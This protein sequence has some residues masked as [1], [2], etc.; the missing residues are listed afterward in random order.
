[1]KGMASA[2]GVP[3]LVLW[4]ALGAPSGAAAQG[5][6]G[7]AVE[8]AWRDPAMPRSWFE[9]PALASEL[10]ITE[11]RQSPMLDARVASGEL[12]PV[13]ERLPLDPPVVEPYAEVGA[14]GGT[15]VQYGV[16]LETDFF[17][18]IGG[19]IGRE[20]LVRGTPDGTGFVPWIAERVELVE[21]DTVAEITMREGMRWS[22]GTP[23]VA[24]EEFAF[25]F[26]ETLPAVGVDPAQQDP[27]ILGL[28]VVD[29]NTVR[30][31]LDR[32]Y[33]VFLFQFHTAF[34][35][36]VLETLIPMAPAH[37][38]REHL[39]RFV[40]EEEALARARALGFDAVEPL[41]VAL[42]DQVQTIDEPRLGV[43]VTDAYVA[44]SRT[45][46]ELVLERNPYYPF[47][48]TAGNQLPYIDR[49]VVRFAAQPDNVELQAI[50]GG[51]DVLVSA[52]RTDRIPV[53]I[54][55]EERG[56]YRTLIYQDA[57]LSKPFYVFN[58]TPPEA[59]YGPVFA[60]VRF[61][62]AM[63]L[64]LN[65]DGINDRFYFG[66]GTPTQATV[67]PS[68]PLFRPEYAQAFAGHDPDAARAL[69]DEMGLADRDGD[70]FRDFPDGSPFTVRMMYAQ[71]EY[72]SPVQLH[73]Y[74]VS[75]WAA[76]G[77]KV[78]I[79]TVAGEVFWT[80][81]GGNQWDMKPHVLDFSI[82]YPTGF[83]YFNTPYV[84]PE[85]AP[86]GDYTP[87]MRSGGAE[88]V[89]PPPALMGELR[90]LYDAADAYLATLD[91]AAL[92]AILDSQAENLWTIGTVGFPPK[93]VLVAE[94]I[95]NVPERLLWDN[96]LG[97]E[98]QM[99]PYQ[100]FIAE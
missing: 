7:G 64:A 62:R 1:M 26:D 13:R 72:L 25:Y 50:G 2:A 69:L 10:G 80:R 31:R 98:M 12:P 85:I 21:G 77:I 73:E 59:E 6:G 61:R 49:I 42:S 74:A 23:F 27:G 86:F 60:D 45:E 81:S 43:P 36:D 82:P 18:F 16:D 20:G 39:P 87:W 33:P 32:P 28:E 22:D 8:D 95:R 58:M 30:I 46:S 96:V 29:D 24:A 70:G 63:S 89:E 11:F 71:E 84:A 66:R 48:D 100:W 4:A 47:V 67:A 9:A 79:E 99:R 76:V 68:N 40:G 65:R 34:A 44:V 37:L 5:A 91:P 51:S 88:G 57:A 52:A 75:N 56:G 94:R 90:A 93:P 78:E 41:L 97:A 38:M 15:L 92:T 35:P 17:Q 14:Y 19:A 83:V 3:A 53:Y 54:E 55:N